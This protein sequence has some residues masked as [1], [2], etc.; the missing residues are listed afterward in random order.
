MIIKYVPTIY[1]Y[2]LKRIILSLFSGDS[3]NLIRYSLL[4][5]QKKSQSMHINKELT[6]KPV[7]VVNTEKKFY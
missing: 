7:K 3:R 1:G 5:F 6:L 2:L 4:F